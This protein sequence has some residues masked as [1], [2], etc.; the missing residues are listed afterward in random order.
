MV[1]FNSYVKLPE[2]K[3]HK[4]LG[5]SQNWV[6]LWSMDDD[7]EGTLTHSWVFELEMG[8]DQPGNVE[9]IPS[10]CHLGP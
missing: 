6:P 1:M 8:S 5:M 2:G 4:R 10:V 7:F 3:H 9:N